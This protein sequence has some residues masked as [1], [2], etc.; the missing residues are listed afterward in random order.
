MNPF[1][2]TAVVAHFFA[3]DR[4]ELM[5]VDGAPPPDPE[6]GDAEY[7]RLRAILAVARQLK[8]TNPRIQI[9]AV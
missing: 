7:Y 6:N 3:G 9:Y 1:D 8:R 5:A 2:H 4:V